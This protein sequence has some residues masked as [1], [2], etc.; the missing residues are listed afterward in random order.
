MASKTI[1]GL[2]G[3]V[4]LLGSQ[5]HGQPLSGRVCND[6]A[7]R[8]PH[9][10]AG[11]FLRVRVCAHEVVHAASLCTVAAFLCVAAHSTEEGISSVHRQVLS[12]VEQELLQ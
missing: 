10:V 11:I 3:F 12:G 8:L 1:Q 9:D 5:M 6:G 7:Q 4:V 2:Q